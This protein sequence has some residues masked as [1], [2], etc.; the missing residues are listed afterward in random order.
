MSTMYKPLS[1]A[2]PCDIYSKLLFYCCVTNL[3]KLSSLKQYMY[4][5]IF[6]M[7]QESKHSLVVSSARD[8][9]W[10]QPRCQPGLW[11][12]LSFRILFPAHIL[13]NRIHFL[14]AV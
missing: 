9:T 8:M 3:H 2:R 6:T 7:I 5:L 11:S 14:T 10:L 4:Y 1:N 12:H 13:V